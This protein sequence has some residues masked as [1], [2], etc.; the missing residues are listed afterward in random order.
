MSLLN[1]VSYWGKW[2]VAFLLSVSQGDSAVE[3][4]RD[5]IVS[6]HL[7]NFTMNK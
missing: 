6:L 5:T 1:L 3:I 7:V 2:D 4:V